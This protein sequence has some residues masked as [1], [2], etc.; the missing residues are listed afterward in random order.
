MNIFNKIVEAEHVNDARLGMPATDIGHFNRRMTLMAA[1]RGGNGFGIPK[2]SI[3]KRADGKTRGDVKREMR[4]A[5][6]TK[7][8]EDRAPEFMHSAA[9][10]R[11]AA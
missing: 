9:R 2:K 3:A 1:M 8:N 5:A 10:R 11:A 7:V 6:N 4:A